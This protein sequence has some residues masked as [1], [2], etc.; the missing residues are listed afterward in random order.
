MDIDFNKIELYKTVTIPLIIDNANGGTNISTLQQYIN[1]EFQ[2]D[3][4]LLKTVSI[5]DGSA[6]IDIMTYIKSDLIDNN[7]LYAFMSADTINQYCGVPFRLSNKNINGYYNFT[8]TSYLGS[9]S[10]FCDQ[11]NFVVVL[12]LVFIKYQKKS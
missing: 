7:I 4:V 1:V 6:Q 2:P 9:T 11:Y 12:V 5:F 3:E 8:F 10:E